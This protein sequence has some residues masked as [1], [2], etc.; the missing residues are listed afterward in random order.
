MSEVRRAT[1]KSKSW[2]DML[3]SI[4]SEKIANVNLHSEGIEPLLNDYPYVD[5]EV[6]K[7]EFTYLL[8][9]PRGEP[10]PIEMEFFFRK[11]SQLFI[12]NPGHRDNLSDQVLFELRSLLTNHLNISPGSS[13][14][15]AGIWN[16]IQ[17]ASEIREI[18]I[19]VDQDNQ[20]IGEGRLLHDDSRIVSYERLPPGDVIGKKKVERAELVFRHGGR[21]D[22]IY[23]DDLLSISGTNEQFEYVIQ[24]FETEAIYNG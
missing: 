10:T 15:R 9:S 5:Q 12:L 3:S 17:S 4:S 6:I 16:F 22:T 14:S 19:Q 11:E 23:S 8:Q 18:K 24:K 20:D 21:F 2:K 13:I 1:P 7:G